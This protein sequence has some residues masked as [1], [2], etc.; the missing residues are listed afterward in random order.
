MTYCA[1]YCI[2]M[3]D[4][5]P[6][7]ELTQFMASARKVL[8]EPV[9]SPAWQEFAGASNLIGWRFRASSEDWLT[10][11]NSVAK[12]GDGAGH[13]ELFRRERAL[14]GMFSTG[15]SLANCA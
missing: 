14:F 6:V 3:P 9:K 7:E 1:E 4:D 2:E 5:F 15:V 10:Y 12:L 8:L 13:D 11:K